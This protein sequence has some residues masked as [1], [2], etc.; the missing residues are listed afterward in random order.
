MQPCLYPSYISRVSIR[1]SI[2]QPTHLFIRLFNYLPTQHN[3]NWQS[4]IFSGFWSAFDYDTKFL[5]VKAPRVNSHVII[6]ILCV[7]LFK[8]HPPF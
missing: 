5:F 6:C 2:H 1:S 8:K 4:A 3:D 7:K